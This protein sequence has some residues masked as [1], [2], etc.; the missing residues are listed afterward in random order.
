MEIK[1]GVTQKTLKLGLGVF[2]IIGG[3]LLTGFF[4]LIYFFFNLNFLGARIFL[5]WEIF[6]LNSCRVVFRVIIDW[7]RV[8]FLIL[9]FFISSIVM[10]YSFYYMEGDKDY[11]R[12]SIILL[13]FVISI[14]FLILRP[15]LISLLL[16]WDGLG[17]TSY[18]LVIYYQRESSCN[19]GII[20]VLRN[21]VGDSCILLII[22]GVLYKGGWNFCFFND[23]ADFLILLLILGSFTKRAQ[24]PF[25][26]WLPAAMAAPTP[27]SSLVHSSTLVTA[28]V[29]LLIRFSFYI[30]LKGLLFICFRVGLLTIMI[31]GWVANFETDLKKVIALSTLRQ[32]GLMIIVLG[33][34]HYILA[35]FHLVIHAIFKSTLFLRSGF[36]IHNNHGRQDGRFLGSMGV[37]SPI[38]GV[39]FCCTNLALC[40]FPFLA[41]FFSKD[42]VMEMGFNRFF[43]LF[44]VFL[45]ILCT[46]LTV[47]YRLRVLYII[48]GQVGKFFVVG[49]S[50]DFNK[51]LILRLFILFCLRFIGGFIL[52]FFLLN[53]KNL[54]VLGQLEKF[55]VLIVCLASFFL[56]V[57]LILFFNKKSF[58]KRRF[59][60]FN[61]ILFLP[62]IR[63]FYLPVFFLG[64]GAQGFKNLD[65]GWLEVIGPHVGKNQLLLVSGIFQERQFVKTITYYV[66]F[67]LVLFVGLLIF[68]CLKS[69][70]SF[71]LKL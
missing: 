47:L 8:S 23:M 46:G 26:A 40:G 69:S 64:A 20:T 53:L 32:L 43:Y 60:F 1:T 25:S 55:Y 59:N 30:S 66:L 22:G 17:L 51:L 13:M 52:S 49:N 65:K 41:G 10:F 28:G 70:K 63:T 58:L 27:V 21:R 61:L 16:G 19:S 37:R 48:R 35:F 33:M 36:I 2:K 39:I 50:S 15:N 31:R 3:V 6:F 44:T 4:I 71:T 18:A 68:F 7:I 45:L 34:G 62:F 54:Y 12:F 5:E 42:L 56:L 14:I 38:L 29:Y 57:K 11:F 24:I 9:V 67:S